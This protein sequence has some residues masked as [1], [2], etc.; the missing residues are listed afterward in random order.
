M[1][2][3][4][5]RVLTFTEFLQCF[6]SIFQQEAD[7]IFALQMRT[8]KYVSEMAHPGLCSKWRSRI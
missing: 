7:R 8:L 5:V 1:T 2:P 6:R 4:M 3:G